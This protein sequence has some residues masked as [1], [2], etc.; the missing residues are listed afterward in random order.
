[1]RGELLIYTHTNKVSGNA[2]LKNLQCTECKA[3]AHA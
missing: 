3:M 1:M 2:E